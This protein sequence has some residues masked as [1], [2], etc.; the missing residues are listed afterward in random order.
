MDKKIQKSPVVFW[1][2]TKHVL[3]FD[4]VKHQLYA[5]I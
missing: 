3:G 2:F 5:K 1:L 4:A